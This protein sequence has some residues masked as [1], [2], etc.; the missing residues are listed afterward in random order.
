MA[1]LQDVGHD[2]PPPIISLSIATS[3]GFYRATCRGFPHSSCWS[4][5]HRRSRLHPDRH[6]WKAES[7]PSV[8]NHIHLAHIRPWLQLC[9]RHIEL[10]RHCSPLWNIDS[11]GLDQ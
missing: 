2:S 3:L 5:S 9:Q 8:I 10:K 7:T 1:H 11:I 6:P 4:D